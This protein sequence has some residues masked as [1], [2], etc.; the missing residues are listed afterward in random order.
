MRE[1]KLSNWDR[2]TSDDQRGTLNLIDPSLVVEAAGLVRTGRI[3][4]LAIPVD[5]EFSSPMRDG[6]LHVS[7]IRKDPTESQRQVAIDV[8]A[9]HTHDFTHMDAL[10]HV[11]YGGFLYNGVASDSIGFKGAERLGMET[12][13]AIA[14]RAILADVAR[15]FNVDALEP[16]YAITAEDL[17]QTLDREGVTP[18]SGDI[19]LI[20]TGW[21]SRYLTDRSVALS[22][23]PGIG[24]S[25]VE[26]LYNNSITAVGADNLAVEVMPFEDDRRSFVV[27]EQYIRDLGGYLI[28]FMNLEELAAD[29]VYEAFFLLAPLRLVG[30]L[31]SPVTPVALV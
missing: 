24:I 11:G 31:G 29:E 17:D 18:R 16:G 10:A 19:L 25:T 15:T 21:I 27:H 3:Y 28:E 9:M 7:T 26:W 13:G 20:R 8:I 14:G 4:P 5:A 1:N 6:A 30:G 12:F 22:G 2:W 23:W